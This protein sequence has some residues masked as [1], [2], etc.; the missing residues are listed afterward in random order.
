MNSS[1][2]RQSFRETVA[3]GAEKARAKLP[4]AVNGRVESAVKLVLAHDVTPQADGTIEVGSS[5]DPLKIYR[6]QGTACECQDFTRGQ[7]PSGWCM[8]RIAAG[9]QKRVDAVLA[10]Q[11][12]QTPPTVLPVSEEPSATS[13]APQGLGEAPA[14]V[15]C[16][17]QIAGR[18]VQLTLSLI[19]I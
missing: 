4:Q 12:P 2:D 11:A 16:H 15:N 5:S 14:S 8:H 7:A 18:Q 9:I 6:L 10:A 19:H 13:G 1:T 17:I 3:L